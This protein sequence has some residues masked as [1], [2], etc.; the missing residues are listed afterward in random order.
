M[1]DASCGPPKRVVREVR[2]YGAARR[3]VNRA[4]ARAF[5]S[6]IAPPGGIEEGLPVPQEPA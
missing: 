5:A 4:A 3:R 6:K 2:C 1:C